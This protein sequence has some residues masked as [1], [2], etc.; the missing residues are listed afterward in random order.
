M[1]NEDPDLKFDRSLLGAEQDMGSVQVTRE[2][3]VRFA[4]STGETN[5]IYFDDEAGKKSEHGSIIA[6]PT[7]CNSFVNGGTRPDIGLEFGDLSLFAGQSIESL[8]P[9]KPN[10]SLH[11]STKLKEV[12]AKTGRSGKMV[13]TVWQTSFKNQDGGTVALVEESFVSRKRTPR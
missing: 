13:F 9:V 3:I 10:D 5:P 1:T 11:A 12:Y 4:R 8:A 6:P 7:F 2:M